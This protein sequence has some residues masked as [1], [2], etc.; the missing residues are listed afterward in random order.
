M[1]LTFS[2]QTKK[3]NEQVRDMMNIIAY[4]DGEKDLLWI[5]E[6]ID[7][8]ISSLSIIVDKLIDEGLLVWSD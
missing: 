3:T 1:A 5:A 7:K 8:P 6:K 2:E 4:C